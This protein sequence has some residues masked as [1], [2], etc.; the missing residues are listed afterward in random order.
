MLSLF[1]CKGNEESV[2]E[3]VYVKHDATAPTCDTAGNQE[4]YT[5]SDCGAIFDSG[6]NVIQSVP[7][8]PATGHSYQLNEESVGDCAHKG[9]VSHYECT[10]CHK[11]FDLLKNEITSIE[12]DYDYANHAQT[13]FMTVSTN[14]AKLAYKVG[15]SFDPTGMVVICKCDSCEGTV[16]D[17]SQLA[18]EYQSAGATAFGVGDTK[19]TVRL[20]QMSADV[21]V[22]V[23]RNQAE[24]TGVLST[25]ETSCGVAPVIE[26]VSSVSSLEIHVE[27][28]DAHSNVVNP[29]DFVA[30]NT[31][32]ARVYVE[33]TD[34]I[35]GAEVTATV[36][37]VHS[38]L[39]VE[40]SQDVNKLVYR[41]A[42]GDQEDFYA[43]SNQV[44]YVDNEDMSIDLSK[45]VVG[46]S[47]YSVVEIQQILLL[48][49]HERV[50]IEGESNGFVYTFDVDKYEKT[51]FEVVEGTTVYYTP[52]ELA[53]AVSFEIEGRSCTVSIIS[54][55]VDKVIRDAEDLLTLAYDGEPMNDTGYSKTG[56]YVLANDIDAT[57]LVISG[58]TPAFQA[59][60]GFRGVFEGQ[61]YSISNLTVP[62]WSNGL[63]GAI[64]YGAIIRNVSFEDVVVP[65]E[66]TQASGTYVFAYA[67]RNA[68]LSN[69]SVS[70]SAESIGF[71]LACEINET[72]IDN[73]SVYTAV[74]EEAS[75]TVNKG[76][77]G[78]G[79]ISYEY[80]PFATVTFDT[81][82]GNA[83]DPIEITVGKKVARPEDPTKTSP[84]YDYEFIGWYLNNEE[85]DFNSEI[86]GDIVLVAKWNQT[87]KV[88]VQALISNLPDSVTM[89]DHA[90]FVSRILGAKAAYD[91]LTPEK[92]A[93]ITNYA[94]LES[95]LSDIDG[96]ESAF[97]QGVSKV[98]VIAS[99]VPNY[100]SAVGGTASITSDELY[101]NSLTVA[102]AVDGKA[103]LH[104]E[105]IPSVA[106][107]EK[108]YFF[109]KVSVSCDI[110]LSDG[111]TNDGWGDNWKN[112]WSASGYWCNADNW[113]LIEINVA[114]G[115]V[116]ENFAIGFRTNETGF[117]FEVTDFVGVCKSPVATGL[118]FGNFVNSGSTNDHGVVY[119]FT[120]GWSS[121][122]DMGAFN[123]GALK[124]A[125]AEG[126]DALCFWIYNPNATDVNFTFNGDMNVWAPS[127]DQVT[128]LKANEWTKVVITPEIIE[129]GN[130]GTWFVNVSSGANVSGWQISAIYAIIF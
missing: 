13:A 69:V 61:G 89:P 67:I 32:T 102:S 54:K 65:V 96:Y 84:D 93:E 36:N 18:F 53:L 124:N 44:V 38:H 83:I 56:H 42:C 51:A 17:N 49:G 22:T 10:V 114:D 3:H 47:N 16:I 7:T 35:E 90:Y 82:G 111:I 23:E 121:A 120:Q 100:T 112:T 19:I 105:N 130:S 41:C 76:N 64:G 74:G 95:L 80:M 30:G 55:Y 116:G 8:L 43:L 28:L 128:T 14:P 1:A 73:V 4:Y 107:Y 109:V 101:G 113:R 66:V 33:G 119:N 122:T 85:Y 129:M 79:D 70:F 31:Y 40:D 52:Y 77:S 48:N 127:G 39:W 37:V 27:Y 81:D 104:Y 118:T 110:Y 108:I 20:G 60:V 46:T 25:Y 5:C 94:K 11:L 34:Q 75:F 126:Y 106:R 59:A 26:A 72:V 88:D 115:Y 24:I 9:T 50:A 71:K 58:S 68:T 87:E 15:E 103:A 117:T 97:T 98:N 91:T 12:G 29:T 92:Q 99:Y 78:S 62:A 45:L 57:G 21:A 2:K 125:V 123:Q 6:K 86:A 63:F